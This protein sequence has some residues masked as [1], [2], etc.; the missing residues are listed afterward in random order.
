MI[1]LLKAFENDFSDLHLERTLSYTKGKFC[2]EL[3]PGIKD[4]PAGDI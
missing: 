3:F 4:H 1:M 2:N